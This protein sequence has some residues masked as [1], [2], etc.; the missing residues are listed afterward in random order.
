M[1]V[2]LGSCVWEVL[3]ITIFAILAGYQIFLPPVTGLANNSDFVYVLG[4]LTIC[5]ADHD[6]QDKIYL[7]TDYFV[8]PVQCTWDTGLTTVE[9]P[10]VMVAQQL[11]RPFTGDQNFDLRALAAVHLLILVCAF[12]ILLSVTRRAGRAV[13]FGIPV[14]FILI[15]SDVAYTAYLNSVYLDAPAMVLLLAASAIGVAACLNHRRWRVSISYL[16]L[17]TALVFAKS[18]HAILGLAFAA[19]AIT[20]AFRPAT[21]IFRIQWAAIG[22]LLIAS[23]GTMLSRTPDHYKLFALYNVIFS[24]LAPH[25]LMPESVLQQVGLGDE[26]RKLVGGHAYLP[27]APVYNDEWAAN[28]LR[29]TSFAKLISYYI[30]N[31]E[32][33]VREM[34]IDL[35]RDAPVLRPKNMA[36]FRQKDGYPPGAMATRFSFWSNLRSRVLTVFPYHVP[37]LF[38]APWFLWIASWKWRT[39]RFRVLPLAL[40]LSAGGVVEFAMSALTDALDNSRHLFLFQVLTEIMILFMAGAI[41]KSLG[42]RP[43]I[44]LPRLHL[45]YPA[46]EIRSRV[47]ALRFSVWEISCFM[48]FLI[49]IGY[50]VF[51]PP[52]TGLADN[53]EFQRVLGPWSIC[54][55]HQPQQNSSLVTD[56]RVD[57]DCQY[58]PGVTTIERPMVG[59]GLWM[60]RLLMGEGK[61]DLRYLAALHL[62]VLLMGFAVML[63]LT[64]RARPLLRWGIPILFILIFSDIAYTGY[65][66]SAY[67]DAPAFVFLVLVV[68]IAAVACFNCQSWL[69]LLAYVIAVLCLVFA[70][71]QH[72]VLGS[73]F[74]VLAVV[75]AFRSTTRVRRIQWI[76]STVL[77]IGSVVTMISLT[78][79]HDQLFALYSLIFSRLVPNSET[80]VATL[81]DLGLSGSD[82]EYMK[83]DAYTPGVPIYTALWAEDFLRRTSFADVFVYYLQNPGVPLREMHHELYVAAPVMR[84]PDIPNYRAQ[85]HPLRT[86]ATRFSFW[87]NLR[88]GAI[89]IFPY[90]LLLIYVAPWAVAIAAWRMRNGR[91]RWRL[92]PLGLVLSAAGILAFPMATL[93]DALGNERHLFLFHVITELLLVM[94][95]AAVLDLLRTRQLQDRRSGEVLAEQAT[96]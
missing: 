71:A 6:A 42:T 78:P 19:V 17:T 27:D 60:S 12:G 90:H 56:Y 54:S 16:L 20:L 57:P 81:R 70:K 91:F 94:I 52:V 36:N 93:T 47:R 8:D 23:T 92:L 11:S 38:L 59:V 32:V 28:F 49:L 58:D 63:S 77:L 73:I 33:A 15:F 29:R 88:S 75:F 96:P 31:P 9:V 24:R 41:L 43:H 5:P 74:A 34:D 2:R 66:N 30:H 69:V 55:D 67:L 72:A 64:R 85:D 62:A 95:A 82:L 4:K 89:R 18:Q 45:R 76:A 37:L 25:N 68:A 14:L 65:L 86:M 22:V 48:V 61:F 51:V 1:Q 21:R 83:T 80:P 87:S 7:V 26:D 13:R 44:T 39:L 10:L 79:A 84:P 50:Q 40:A 46:L 35:H 53:S 3:C